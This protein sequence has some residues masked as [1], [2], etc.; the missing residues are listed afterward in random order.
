MLD[1]AGLK[2]Y[3][4]VND[5]HLAEY[6][7]PGALEVDSNASRTRY[8]QA[9]VGA[10]FGVKFEISKEFRWRGAKALLIEIFLDGRLVVDSFIRKPRSTRPKVSIWN[11][12]TMAC[13]DKKSVARKAKMMFASVESGTLSVHGFQSG[14]FIN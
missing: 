5:Q 14:R 13:P 10:A 9:T 2:V 4:V 11:E 1:H 12:T 7:V 6:R 3:I 8:V